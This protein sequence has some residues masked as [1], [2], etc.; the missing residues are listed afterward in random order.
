[1]DREHR[2]A[3]ETPSAEPSME[4]RLIHDDRGRAWIGSTT[5]GAVGGGE[6]N[7]EVI[8]VCRDQPSELKRIAHLDVSVDRADD[9]WRTMHDEEVRDAFRRS[10]PA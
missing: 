8:F 4:Q 6:A 1:M 7:A 10:F 9:R 2:I 3:D 5:S